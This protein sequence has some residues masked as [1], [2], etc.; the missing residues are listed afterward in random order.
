MPSPEAV[1]NRT[2]RALDTFLAA[3]RP[4]QP[5]D[6]PEVVADHA[7]ALGARDA[8]LFLAD[9]QQTVLL[10]FRAPSTEP[11]GIHVEPLAVDLTVAG[12]A[13]R[14]VQVMTQAHEPG[15]PGI[16]VW[17]PVVDGSERL[18]VLGATVDSEEALHADD[19]ALLTRLR[20]LATLAADLL[21][22][23]TQ[24]GDSV[25]CARRVSTMGLAAEVQWGLLPPLTFAC[26]RIVV[27]GALEPAYDVAGDSFDYAVD[28][29]VARVAVFDGMGHGLQSSLMAVLAMSTYRN[30]RR[31]GHGL[32]DTA[33]LI[34]EVIEQEFV[35]EA[36]TT[37]V[38]AELD[39]ETGLLSWVNAGHPP[40][41]LLRE[42]R[43]VHHLEAS[44]GLPFGIGL[45]TED[46]SYQ[47]GR[48]RLQPGDRVLFYT[49]GVIEARSPGGELFGVDRL[50][51]LL[52]RHL[53]G[54]LPTP[55][56]LR[57]TVHALLEHQEGQLNDDATMLLLGWRT[58]EP[59]RMQ[60]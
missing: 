7:A 38:L 30:A 10:P 1:L 58:D 52:A 24:Y 34:D 4:A 19:D 51:D 54:G 26:D 6:V 33:R 16:R 9:L 39:G 23:K 50:V 31:A 28:R 29:G 8:T 40:P 57:R 14:H 5:H 48:E 13:Y 45:G 2:E 12:H 21:V 41:F 44:S 56:T 35:A 32:Q 22:S 55:E 60:L 42:G 36:F 49:D 17:L 15:R 27:A 11:T 43:L 53:A 47:L 3:A 59:A 37:A 46:P 20:R 18:G 25:V